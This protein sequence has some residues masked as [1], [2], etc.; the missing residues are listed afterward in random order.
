VRCKFFGQVTEVKTLCKKLD[1]SC[2][3]STKVVSLVAQDKH[4]IKNRNKMNLQDLKQQESELKAKLE[5]NHAFQNKIAIERTLR[6]LNVQ[7]GDIIQ[8]QTFNTKVC[9]GQLHSVIC[10]NQD[11]AKVTALEVVMLDDARKRK[12]VESYYFQTVRKAQ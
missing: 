9:V 11:P 10:S 3:N 6:E 1:Y 2:L 12:F 5:Q 8:F 4:N 7:I